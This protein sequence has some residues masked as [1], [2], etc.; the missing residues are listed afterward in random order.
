MVRPLSKRDL[1]EIFCLGCWMFA[2]MICEGCGS[3]GG[4]RRVYEVSTLHG[5]E[6]RSGRERRKGEN[7]AGYEYYDKKRR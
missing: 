2:M 1:E 3:E 6:F 4:K 7:D 5:G